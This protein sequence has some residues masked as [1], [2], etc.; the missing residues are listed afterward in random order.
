MKHFIFIAICAGFISCNSSDD[1]QKKVSADSIKN[2][3]HKMMDRRDNM[4]S[5]MMGDSTMQW[6]MSD[7]PMMK[8]MSPSMMN[9]MKEIHALL[10]NHDKIERKVEERKDGIE[11]WTESDDPAIASAI[12][13]HVKSMK[14]RMEDGNPIRQMDPLFRE[15]FEHSEKIKIKIEETENGVHVIETSNDPE[16]VLLIKQHANKAVSEFVE[17]GMER[18]MKLSPLPDGY[19]K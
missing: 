7:S 15:L 18:A 3:S 16:V 12:K 8:N 4:M 13:N 9:D 5:E 11:S 6:M 19:Q 2:D 14:K 17:Y 1:K 10:V